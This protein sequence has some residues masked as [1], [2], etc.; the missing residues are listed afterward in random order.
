MGDQE[1]KIRPAIMNIH[2]NE[3]L[4]YPYKVLVNKCSGSC[5][6]I[7][8][9]CVPDAV[10]DMNIK[11]FNLMSR[12]TETCHVAWHETCTYKC[13]LDA[14]VCNDQQCFNSN[15]CGC[16]CKKL[17]DKGTCDDGFVWNPSISKCEYWRIF[18]LCKL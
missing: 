6:D 12:T 17:I 18:R 13:K 7:N 3:S 15:K 16:E 11:V 5:N 8:N 4:L 1:C 2:S 10:K 14:S 9:P